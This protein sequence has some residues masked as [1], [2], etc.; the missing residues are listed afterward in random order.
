LDARRGLSEFVSGDNMAN[1]IAAVVEK[2]NAAFAA[3]DVEGFLAHCADDVVFTMVGHRRVEGKSAVREWM[4]HPSSQSPPKFSVQSVIAT[5]DR[6]VCYGDMTMTEADG[7]GSYEYCDVYSFEN[8][9]VKEL[10]A[11]VVKNGSVGDVW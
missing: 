11:Y 2:V 1:E 6:V 7:T 8:G 4:A 9:K 3:G 5:D 10:R